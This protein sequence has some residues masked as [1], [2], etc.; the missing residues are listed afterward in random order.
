MPRPRTAKA[1]FEFGYSCGNDPSG[2]V[3]SCSAWP[4]EHDLAHPDRLTRAFMRG[5]RD[6]EDEKHYERSRLSRNPGKI[7]DPKKHI[8]HLHY[9]LT[10]KE[11]GRLCRTAPGNGKLPRYGY[12]K[13]VST[14][15]GDFWIGRTPLDSWG[16]KKT[17]RGWVW[18]AF[19]KSAR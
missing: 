11:A 18:C 12:E 10:D 2:M 7:R 6:G 13:L 15:E 1:A 17:R 19:P 8:S 16:G 9:L 4:S 3:G 5:Y 14:D